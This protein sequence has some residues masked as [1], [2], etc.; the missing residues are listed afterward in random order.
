M[1]ATAVTFAVPGRADAGTEALVVVDGAGGAPGVPETEGD[2]EVAAVP[3]AGVDEVDAPN[4]AAVAGPP[5]ATLAP[6]P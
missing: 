4:A 3:A 2:E 5:A 1:G 6:E